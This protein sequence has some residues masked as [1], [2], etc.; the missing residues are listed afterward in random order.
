MELYS[1]LCV[2][3][4]HKSPRALTSRNR[5]LPSY[6]WS[7]AQDGDPV[8]S[9]GNL[10]PG[11]T[12]SW[13]LH[14]LSLWHPFSKLCPCALPAGAHG[15]SPVPSSFLSPPQ[16]PL[17]DAHCWFSLWCLIP[18]LVKWWIIAQRYHCHNALKSSETWKVD[19]PEIM[20]NKPHLSSS[21]TVAVF[22]CYFKQNF[23]IVQTY[24]KIY[25]E[26]GLCLIYPSPYSW[27]YLIVISTL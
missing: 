8:A 4:P 18:P 20:K 26:K 19:S 21:G 9:L 3:E 6:I 14:I 1:S 15:D 16:Q 27:F 22:T 23:L 10:I 5:L 17:A 13:G 12:P 2:R 11:Q 24:E 7:L 25:V